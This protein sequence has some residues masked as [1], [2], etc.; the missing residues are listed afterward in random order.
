[1][2]AGEVKSKIRREVWS[3]LTDKGVL[4]FPFKAFGRI[5][6]FRGSERAATLLCAS[7]EF[8]LA[9]VVKVNPDSPQRMVRKRCL[10]EGK[11]LIMPTPR[12]RQGFLLIDP[13][14]VGDASE[15][16]SISG[17]FRMGELVHPRELPQ[18]DLLVFG[19]VAVAPDGARIGKGEGYAEL[20]Y[21]I[22]RHFGKVSSQTPIFT[23]VHPLQV[24]DRIPLEE[25]DVCLDSY[26]TPESR[27]NAQG[28]RSRPRGIIWRLLQERKLR[29][30]P[31]LQELAKEEGVQTHVD[32][33]TRL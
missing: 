1:M 31:L 19:S 7:N 29:E 5:P 14:R 15:A 30:I 33:T 16:S 22:L 3:T 9:A 20:E 18:I 27:F 13:K 4:G 26:F 6:N 11:T 28:M 24:V 10:E 17:A 32:H 21:A 8:K 2:S 25:F 12:M 23:T